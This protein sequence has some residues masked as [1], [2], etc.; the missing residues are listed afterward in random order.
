MRT[1][2]P[3]QPGHLLLDVVDAL[4][5]LGIPYAVIGAFAVSFHGVPRYT[6]DADTAIW[7]T[8][9]GKTSRDLMN[10]FL[11]SGYRAQLMQGDLD[12]PISGSIIVQDG[13]ENRMDILLGIRGMDPGAVQRCVS[14]SLLDSPVR[15]IAAED[16]IA[17]KVFAGGPQDLEDVRGILQ[18]SGKLL[19]LQLLSR[20]AHRYGI[21][22]TRAL[23]KLLRDIMN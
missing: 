14:A 13:Y 12:D 6:D 1:T 16:L 5:E 20:L 23:S 11:D 9:T 21:K 19:D 17:M 22:V 7:L 3:G 8:D 4:V 10:R 15:I 2:G 18:V